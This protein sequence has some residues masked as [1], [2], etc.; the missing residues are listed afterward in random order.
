MRE[1]L[2]NR[3]RSS[4]AGRWFAQKEQSERLILIALAAA[5]AVL[6]LWLGLWRPLAD[7]QSREAS[8]HLQAQNLLAWLQANQSRL[9][10]AGEQDEGGPQTSRPI[11]PIVTRAADAKGLEVSRLQPESDGVISVVLQD[12]KFNDL[13]A[14]IAELHD[15]EGVRVVRASVDSQGEPG[16]VN[17]Q[18]RLQ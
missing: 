4:A 9:R 10:A 18:I 17:A 3:L 1:A 2:A 12:Q 5:M 15:A 11:I 16:Y 8:R 13:M 14:W 7:W 6:F